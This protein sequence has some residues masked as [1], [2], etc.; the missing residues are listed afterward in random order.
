MKMFFS[1]DL[2]QK[3]Y[4]L[5]IQFSI[6]KKFGILFSYYN[7]IVPEGLLIRC[8][9]RW[10]NK[11]S[12][13]KIKNSKTTSKLCSAVRAVRLSGSTRGLLPRRFF[14]VFLRF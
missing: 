14:I 10:H 8:A 2:M 12:S 13:L 5:C 7:G 6:P 1:F 9:T 3:K 4:R 11:R